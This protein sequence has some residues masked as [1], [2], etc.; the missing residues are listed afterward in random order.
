[1]KMNRIFEKTGQRPI[2]PSSTQVILR[3]TCASGGRLLLLLIAISPCSASAQKQGNMWYFGDGY[4]LDF[5]TTP[6]TLLNDGQTAPMVACGDSHIEGTASIADSSGGLLFYT[7]GHTIWNKNHQPMPN[8]TG[9]LGGTSSTQAALIVPQSSSNTRYYVFT[10][11]DFC[12]DLANGLRY[13]V[14]DICED[15]KQGDIVDGFKNQLLLDTVA[16]KL[17]A[18]RHANGEDFWVLVHKY[19]TN[20]FYAFQLTPQ[21]IE[22]PVISSVGAVHEGGGANDMWRALGQMKISPDG[23]RIG[24]GAMNGADIFEVLDFDKSTGVVSVSISL[25]T[26]TG[27]YGIE[28]SP[29]GSKLYQTPLLT[30]YDLTAG[31]AGAILASAYHYSDPHLE[32]GNALQLGPDGKIYMYNCFDND[33]SVIHNPNEAGLNSN[34]EAN[35]YVMPTNALVYGLPSFVAGFDYSASGVCDPSIGVHEIANES[36]SLSVFPNPSNTPTQL[37]YRSPQ[38]T[39]PTLQLRDML[40]RTVQTVQLLSH[41]GTYTLDAAGLGAGVY[42]CSLVS[43]AEVLATEK[44]V[45]QR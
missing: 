19:F 43:G 20:E 4:G 34:A 41:E 5:N 8:G 36:H 15:N 24:I 33:I 26:A 31:S 18:V 38:G 39:R 32:C 44:L 9:L 16:E 37:S 21:G 28:F 17:A 30:Q 13:S 45:V 27:A 25:A 14:V 7:D 2:V 42:F 23:S 29:D 22:E 10:T 12:N 6:P 3:K 11:D 1:M 40:G 35:V